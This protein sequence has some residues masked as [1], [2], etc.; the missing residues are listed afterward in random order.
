MK[1]NEVYEAK[2]LS[3][4]NYGKG[5]AKICD[6]ACF[7]DN[8]YPDEE[9]RIR[10]T[11]VDKK[12]SFGEVVSLTK[13]SPHRIEQVC[14]HSKE[15]G[16]CVYNDIDIDYENELKTMMVKSNIERATKLEI[17]NIEMLKGYLT[18]G[19][20]NKVTV[21]FKNI[22]HEYCFGYFK[23][24]S[25]D[26]VKVDS[27]VQIDEEILKV[28]KDI[29]FLLKEYHI[30]LYDYETKRGIARGVSIRKSFKY[31]NMSVMLIANT[32]HDSFKDIAVKL[33][34]SHPQIKS[35]SLNINGEDNTIVYTGKEYQLF[36][37]DLLKEE[38][39]GLT[40]E[41][42]NRSF[43][44]VNT[45]GAEVL[46][47]AAID[48]ANLSKEDYVLDLY[49]G[50]GGISLNAAKLCKYVYGIESSKEATK[51]AASN[52]TLNKI[53]N[54][55]FYAADAASFKSILSGKRI[56]KIFV[57]PPREGLAEKVI[58]SIIKSNI[59]TIVYVSC[60]SFTLSRDL[61][62]FVENGY[63]ISSVKCVNMFPRT[64][65]VETVCLLIR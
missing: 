45:K 62:I 41:V 1:I 40:Y 11:K 16:T 49:S 35:I 27:C 15:A 19:Y 9:A 3:I 25:H 53:S 24:K 60:D 6:I 48:M 52:K 55:S 38:I 42:K 23:E 39:C 47:N 20:R 36:G 17:G 4:N 57:D 46:Y 29:L 63:N 59:G 12:F 18:E 31:G 50:C 30:S 43:L 54:V 37:V 34:Q 51:L 5:V 7:V 22:N 21:F 8:F 56:D 14:H 26:I 44:Q 33:N 61:K 10:I 2:C 64:K 32:N 28:I 13:K 58:D 65:H